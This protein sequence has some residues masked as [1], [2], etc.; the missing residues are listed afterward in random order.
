[1]KLDITFC[2]SWPKKL[3]IMLKLRSVDVAK[4]VKISLSFCRRAVSGGGER[5][6][7]AALCISPCVSSKT[8]LIVKR[9]TLPPAVAAALLLADEYRN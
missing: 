4:V 6:I 3:S 9:E 8:V 1:M 2:I 5:I 7:S